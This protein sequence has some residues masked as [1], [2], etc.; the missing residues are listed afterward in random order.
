MDGQTKANKRPRG[1]MGGGGPMMMSVEK[2]KDFKGSIIKLLDSL[3]PFRVS[4]MITIVFAVLGTTFSIASPKILGNMTNQIVDDYISIKVFEAATSNLP[5][6]IKL[7]EGTTIEKLPETLKSMVIE[8]KIRPDQLEK[9]SGASD[10]NPTA[11]IPDNQLEKIKMLDLSKRPEMRYDLLYK[12]ALVLVMLYIASTVFGFIQGWIIAGVT[13]KLVLKFRGDI[14]QKINRLPIKYFDKHSYGD[15][16][17]R[18]T[19]D[20]DTV[21][22][23]L[24]QSLSQIITSITMLIGIVIMMISISVQMTLVAVLTLPIGFAFIIFIT[25]NSQ[26]HFKNQQS[27]LGEL[28]GHIEEIYSGQ[29]IVKAFSGEEK[30]SKRFSNINMR[31]HDSSWKSQFLSGLMMPIMHFISN[32]GYVASTVLG[33]WLAINGKISIGDIQAFIQYVNQ[34]NNPM[35]QVAQI[36]NVLQSTVAA[37]ERVFEFLEEE[38]ELSDAE[39]LEFTKNIRGEVE[40]KNVVFGYSAKNDV[41]KNFSVRVKPGQKV[42]IVGPTGAGKTTVVNLLMRFYDPRSGSILIDGIDTKSVKRADVRKQFGMVLQ[43]TWLFSGTIHDNLTYGDL[44]ADRTSVMKSAKAAHVDHFVQSLAHGYKTVLD[45]D[46]DG[47][48]VGEKQLLTIARAMLADAPMMILDEATSSVDTRTEVL[49]QEAM[50]KLTH[51]RTSFIIAHRLSTI[52]NA[53]LILVMDKGNII[54]QGHHKEL[55]RAGGFY[56]NLYNSQFVEE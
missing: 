45:G 42:A 17:S 48:S 39:S 35:V 52:R 30:A 1:P 33:G 41:I 4:I 23:S 10:A 31:L 12:T 34:L 44:K 27:Q 3:K 2:P 37:S 26:K 53:D 55:M 6:D 38:E 5:D 32:L 28:N 56:A 13:Q 50:E 18:V 9:F 14:S 49:I 19:N 15:L 54:E 29:T 40:F 24:N 43:D 51:G 20:V 36:M 11:K 21:A 22:Q 7:P 47:I 25:K 8:G 16:L 46:S